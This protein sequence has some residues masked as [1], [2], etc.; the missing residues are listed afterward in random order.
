MPSNALHVFDLDGTLLRVNSFRVI[1][2]MVLGHW[3]M[4]GCWLSAC[5]VIIAWILRR[6]H[7]ISHLRFKQ[8]VVDAFE[9]HLDEDA[10]RS[11]IRQVVDRYGN[12]RVIGI[13]RKSPR[14]VICTAAPWSF[15]SRM[16]FG[17]DAVLI[18]ALDVKNPNDDPSN[19]GPAKLVN[20]KRRFDGDADVQVLYTDSLE[21]APLIE[22]A[23]SAF[24]VQGD[25]IQPI[26]RSFGVEANQ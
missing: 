11:L 7:L 26:G 22:S 3:A 2:K 1:T 4:T 23:R 5:Y 16:D 13:F 10:K 18:S 17:A 6:A 21:D 19:I 9:Q 15:A 14:R 8:I 25:D 24:L 20:L 12:S